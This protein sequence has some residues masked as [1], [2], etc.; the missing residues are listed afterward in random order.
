MNILI[1]GVAGFIG[2]HLSQ[3]LLAAGFRVSGIDNL[4]T[5]YDVQ[6]K[7]DRLALLKQ[8]EA[9]SFYQIDL[10]QKDEL[11]QVFK[12]DQITH[13]VNLACGIH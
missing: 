7:H 3:K 5:Y 11:A 13:V 10:N 1:T 9:F 8:N 12:N 2:F 6:L 4:N